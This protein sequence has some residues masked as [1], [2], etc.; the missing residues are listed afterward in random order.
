M[1]H[2]TCIY[3]ILTLLP[4]SLFSQKGYKSDTIIYQ[5][6]GE[7]YKLSQFWQVG[8]ADTFNL[9]KIDLVVKNGDTTKNKRLFSKIIHK[10]E[11]IN[12]SVIIQKA[13]IGKEIYQ[14]QVFYKHL[15]S[16]LR[17]KDFYEVVYQTDKHGANIKI[18]NCADLQ[19]HL[20]LDLQ[21]SIDSLKKNNDENVYLF[22]DYPK[23]MK[24]C[25]IVQS[26]LTNDLEMFHQLYNQLVPLKDT[27]K[28]HV[29]LTDTSDTKREMSAYFQIKLT[30]KDN[31]NKVFELSEDKTKGSTLMNQVTG[32]LAKMLTNLADDSENEEDESED[33]SDDKTIVE[34]DKFNYPV[35]IIK[36]DIST[37]KTK[38]GLTVDFYEYKIERIRK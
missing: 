21:E 25:K 3:L 15:P 33:S 9:S 18:L 13:Q 24:D 12:D 6:Q 2:V 14:E 19:S 31:G 7:P 4:I 17:I 16:N 37:E 30:T 28:F 11:A 1:K 38:K 34:V 20:I 23:R 29:K 27:L 32:E 22:S 36:R 35:K 8:K 10:I 26:F 5:K